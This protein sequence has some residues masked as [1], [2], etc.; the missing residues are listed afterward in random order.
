VT[1]GVERDVSDESEA[2]LSSLRAELVGVR[3]DLKRETTLAKSA[4]RDL[5][6]ANRARD[7]A[8]SLLPPERARFRVFEGVNEGGEG[9]GDGDSRRRARRGVARLKKM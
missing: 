6:D 1:D 5:D 8:M 4:L 2:A 9:G 3:E 7:E